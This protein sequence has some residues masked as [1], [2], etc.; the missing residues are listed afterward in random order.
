MLT[1]RSQC[2]TST[3]QGT[4]GERWLLMWYVGC[5]PVKGGLRHWVKLN[6]SKFH[7]TFANK[8]HHIPPITKLPPTSAIPDSNS[9]TLTIWLILPYSKSLPVASA[10]LSSSSLWALLWLHIYI[11]CMSVHMDWYLMVSISFSHRD[12]SYDTFRWNWIHQLWTFFHFDCDWCRLILYRH[13]SIQSIQRFET[14]S[15]WAQV[16]NPA[17][18]LWGCF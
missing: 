10:L 15:S 8:T 5:L 9:T 11:S 18:L 12:L 16:S 6:S 13:R 2:W 14:R 4:R 7:S 1:T 3:I 17:G